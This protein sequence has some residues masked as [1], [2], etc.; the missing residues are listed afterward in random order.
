MC[1]GP[2]EWGV[3]PG[4]TQEDCGGQLEMGKGAGTQAKWM[5]AGPRTGGWV[6]WA[7]GFSA[8]HWPISGLK[9]RGKDIGKPI[10]KGPRAK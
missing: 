5:P 1:G 6:W 9:L 7:T 4:G 10:E 2:E 3:L 8:A